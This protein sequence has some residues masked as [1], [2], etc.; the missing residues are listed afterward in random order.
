MTITF[1]EVILNF[2]RLFFKLQPYLVQLSNLFKYVFWQVIL[3]YY[4]TSCSMIFAS[5][6]VCSSELV[7][8][9]QLQ[10]Y[11]LNSSKMI[12]IFFSEVLMNF[13]RFFLNLNFISSSHQYGSNMFS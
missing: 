3:V 1:S 7:V 11:A 4:Y 12:G 9:S 6:T 13:N 2:N 8:N 5:L 10:V